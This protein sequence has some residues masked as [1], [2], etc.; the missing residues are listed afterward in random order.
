MIERTWIPS[1]CKA[2]TPHYTDRAP[3]ISGLG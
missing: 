1:Y 2:S 3:K